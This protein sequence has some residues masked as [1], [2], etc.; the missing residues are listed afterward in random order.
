M[1][2]GNRVTQSMSKLTRT[3][4]KRSDDRF[5]ERFALQW[6]TMRAERRADEHPG[7]RPGES[8]YASGE[9]PYGVALAAAWAWRFLVIIAAGYVLTLGIA[10]FSV[11]V[12]PLVIAM[13][14]TALVVPVVN[15]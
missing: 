7:I 9:V 6:S 2:V 8:N 1:G 10:K 4:R 12:L 13:L 11:V 14:L 5:A 15:A 3:Q